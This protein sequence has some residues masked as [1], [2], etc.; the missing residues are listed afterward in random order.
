MAIR[1]GKKA[2]VTNTWIAWLKWLKLTYGTLKSRF[3]AYYY[4]SFFLGKVPIREDTAFLER[5]E[6]AVGWTALTADNN[7]YKNPFVKYEFYQELLENLERFTKHC[8][9]S[10]LNP[11]SVVFNTDDQCSA[12]DREPD[13]ARIKDGVEMYET[14]TEQV[15]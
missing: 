7:Y 14:K 13:C 11:E 12:I 8:D 1:R 15:I 3:P 10:M 9:S 5:A 2:H 4:K 6:E